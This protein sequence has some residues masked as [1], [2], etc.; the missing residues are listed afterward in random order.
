MDANPT[1]SGYE[2][3]SELARLCLPS[4]SQ[5]ANLKLAWVNS[6]C[7]LFLAIGV[8]GARR[9][10]IS[11]K[12]VPPIREVVPVVV[13]P[14]TLPPPTAAPQK[15][16]QPR[17]E[18]QQPRVLVALPNT[19][20]VNFSV[21]TIGTIVAPGMLASAPP[22][23]PMQP[24]T[25]VA[26]VGNTGTGGDRPQP[27]YPQLAMQSGEQGTIVLLLGSDETGQVVSIDV[28]ESSGFPF[29]D[30]AT[31]AFIKSHWHLPMNMGT[32]L[33]Q[34]SVTYKLQF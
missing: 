3:K 32:R 11:I 17:D 21:P 31:V 23:N 13:I 16:E 25:Q 2:L 30:Q 7:I 26:S 33:F 34:T 10:I 12:T 27:P 8:V 22:L 5:D 19:P 4:A 20:N 9:G 14:V 28:K 18:S 1:S 6:I 29:L 15:K 24:P